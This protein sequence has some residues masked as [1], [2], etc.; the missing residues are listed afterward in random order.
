V[1]EANWRKFTPLFI[2]TAVAL[3]LGFVA[4][5]QGLTK[6]NTFLLLVSGFF[7]WSLIEYGLHRFVFH[8]HAKTRLGRKLLYQIHLS[9]HDDPTATNRI[10]ASL[11]LSVPL[12]AAY[13]LLVWTITASW[14]ATSYL[15]IGMS[16][17]YF[18][19]EWL[20]FQCHHGQ[21]RLRILRY[22]RKY[23]LLHHYKTPELRFGVTSPLFDLMFGTFRRDERTPARLNY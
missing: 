13:W 16:A 11:F 9:H 12:A 23:H 1:K 21:S 17:G 20:H 10:F 18:F 22:L 8:Y 2:Y 15:F 6:S 5:G 3:C 19:Y 14:A 4:A 7:S